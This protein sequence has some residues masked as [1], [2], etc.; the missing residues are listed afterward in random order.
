MANTG[1]IV[2]QNLPYTHEILDVWATCTNGER[3]EGCEKWKMEW[4]HEQS[5]FSEY[6]R[7]DFNPMGDNIRVSCTSSLTSRTQ[8]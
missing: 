3:Y 6:L 5:V 1:F 8:A 4:A 2:A 7:W